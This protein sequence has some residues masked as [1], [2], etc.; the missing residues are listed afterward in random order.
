VSL[1]AEQ[2]TDGS[3]ALSGRVQGAR[4]GHVTIY[5]ERSGTHRETAGTAR[6]GAGGTFTLV[7]TARTRPTFYRAVYVDPAT[8]IPYAKLLRDPV[9]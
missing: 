8:G 6:I 9:G 1:D 7:D 2:R 3:I 4:G 5:R